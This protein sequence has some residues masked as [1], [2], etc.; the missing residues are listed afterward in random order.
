MPQIL[1]TEYVKSSRL[2]VFHA[3]DLAAYRQEGYLEIYPEQTE[4]PF[5]V[6]RPSQVLVTYQ[7]KGK[8]RTVDKKRSI[9]HTYNKYGGREIKNFTAAEYQRFVADLRDGRVEAKWS[10][11]GEGDI[12][13]FLR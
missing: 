6:S 2:E 13:F 5:I 3:S 8:E 9:M 12:Y 11:Y 7:Y 4:P 10:K 1:K